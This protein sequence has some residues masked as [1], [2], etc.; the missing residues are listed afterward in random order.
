MADG[1]LKFDTELDSS[2]LVS[3]LETLSGASSEAMG[4]VARAVNGE[5]AQTFSELAAGATAKSQAIASDAIAAEKL[6]LSENE[7]IQNGKK[8]AEDLYLAS[9]KENVER[10]KA[11]REEEIKT[12]KLSYDLGAISTEEYF[13]RLAQFRDRY[14]EYGSIGWINYTAEIAKHNQKLAD[15]QQ[16]ALESAA[17]TVSDSI[18]R[19]Y[20]SIAKEQDKLRDKLAEFGNI[21]RKNTI[22]GE[23]KLEFLSLA[24]MDRQ[25]E[26]LENY[27]QLLSGVVERVNDFWRTDTA[28]EAQNE[29]NAGLRHAYLSQVRG[30]SVEDAADYAQLILG[31]TDQKLSEYLGAYERKQEIA[32]RIASELFSTDVSDAA[33]SAARNLGAEFNAAL[34]EELS[35]LAGKF[36][37]SGEEA[38]KSFGEG[39]LSGIGDV[40]A[41]LSDSI[42][43]GAR[44]FFTGTSVENNTSYNIYGAATPA[45]TIRYIRQ[46]DELHAM[47]VQQ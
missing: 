43:V 29:K 22:T 5:L 1:T 3:G 17:D 12:L 34:A 30:M 9:L 36:F 25:S 14:F 4:N 21:F 40:M 13:S 6:Y 44:E 16:K 20:E 41:Q 39:F 31:A 2:G 23:D 37:T 26:E 38:C 32:D 11:L 27:A 28:D 8:K 42:A 7:R 15:E 45:E 47:R 46:Y 35:A 33:D 10:I 24:D 19:R 18:K